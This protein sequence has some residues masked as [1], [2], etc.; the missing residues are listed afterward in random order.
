MTAAKPQSKPKPAPRLIPR[1]KKHKLLE[2][3]DAKLRGAHVIDEV[4]VTGDRFQMRTLD[5]TAES[6]ADLQ[7]RGENF[8]QT[9]RNRRAPYVAASLVAMWDDGDPET[10]E[11]PRWV[12]VEEIF[13]PDEDELETYQQTLLENEPFHANWVRSEVMEWLTDKDKH[14]PYVQELFSFYISLEDRRN[15]ALENLD[16]LSKSHRTGE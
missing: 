11:G 5:P 9:A 7:V 1:K 10:D 16:P 3:I 13:A 15:E 4:T 6:W 2:A 12:P 8:Y 14:G